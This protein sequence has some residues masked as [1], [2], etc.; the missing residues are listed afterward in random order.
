LLVCTGQSATLDDGT[1]VR[2]I[3]GLV[4]PFRDLVLWF[5]LRKINRER[6]VDFLQVQNDVFVMLAVLARLTGFHIL[7]DAQVVERDYWSALP[8]ESFRDVV[9]SKVMP[10]C[11]QILCRLSE[12]LS[13]FSDHDAGRIEQ[14]YRLPAE[15]VFIIPL[16][17]RQPKES[18]ISVR[19]PGPRPVVLFLGSYGHRPNADAITILRNEIR[20][21]VIR[22]VP[23]TI[24]QIVGKDLPVDVLEAGGLE[25]HANVDEVTRFIDAATVC[26][27]PVRV[28][29]GV[30]T[31]VVEY[32]SRGKPVVAMTPALEGLA[33]RPGIDLLAADDFDS[34]ADHV[35]TL[36]RDSGFRQRIGASGLSRI[37]ELAGGRAAGRVL[38]AFY[39]R[40]SEP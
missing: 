4:W 33:V 40:G 5:E 14:L 22:K 32:L 28:G 25:A 37:L 15:K 20:P 31:K 7:Y 26:V 18:T 36:I 6:K 10:L 23:E 8:A 11:E 38:P 21:R 9:S 27:A 17:P 29:S 13:V 35:V 30:R 34:F 39:S 1:H 24:F 12:R 3:P 19:S 16:S 2:A